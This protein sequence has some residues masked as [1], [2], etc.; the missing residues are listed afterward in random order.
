MG[1]VENGTEPMGWIERRPQDVTSQ[2]LEY[3]ETGRL[4]EGPRHQRDEQRST[5][6]V[7]V[8]AALALGAGSALAVN[9][10]F[11]D[12]TQAVTLV[13]TMCALG[14]ITILVPSVRLLRGTTPT[15]PVQI[16]PGAVV[17]PEL[18]REGNWIHRNG[19]WVRV[20]SIGRDGSGR[21]QALVSSREVV[22]LATPQTIAGDD[23]RPVVDPVA[24]LRG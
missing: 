20:E 5:I 2:I 10:A 8:L 12:G 13:A 7:V 16:R 11:G 3:A 23:F 15:K 22:E 14:A 4:V 17:Q 24:S 9:G 1:W 18:V 19:A 21:L 6:A